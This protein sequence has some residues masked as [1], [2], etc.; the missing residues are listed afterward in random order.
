MNFCPEK[1]SG[2]F[3]YLSINEKWLKSPDANNICLLTT[4]D[5]INLIFLNV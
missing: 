4:A 3:K 5:H 1:E 2:V